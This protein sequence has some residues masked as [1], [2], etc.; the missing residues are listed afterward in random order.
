MFPVASFKL[1]EPQPEGVDEL[2]GFSVPEASGRWTD[3]KEASICLALESP[4]TSTLKLTATVAA[5]VIPQHSKQAVDILVNGNQVGRWEFHFG[6]QIAERQI[7]IP[8]SVANGARKLLI[9]FLLPDAV[10]PA[11]LKFNSDA[12]MLGI[13]VAQIRVSASTE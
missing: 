12:R 1:T 11:D 10:V 5:F 2:R 3:G 7:V 9:T 8:H 4:A 6:E 13:N